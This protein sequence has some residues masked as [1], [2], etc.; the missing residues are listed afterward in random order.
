MKQQDIVPLGHGVPSEFPRLV[1]AD[2]VQRTDVVETIEATE[3]ERI[4]L[5]ERLDLVSVDRL[6]ATVRMKSA[7]GG[8]MVRVTGS[9]EASVVQSCVVSLEPV[10]EEVSDEFVALF[11]PE[12]L[13]PK[14][15]DEIYIDPTSEDDDF[16]EPIINGKI[17]IGELVIQQLS[18][19]L[20]PYPR[21]E[22]AEFAG[23]GDADDEEIMVEEVET[24]VRP[25]PFAALE[26]LKPK[27]KG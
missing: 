2:A 15:E 5:A 19:A 7:R 22:G 23:F 24:P 10:P 8:Q 3:Q 9:L 14:E 25:N 17:D 1:R 12:S 20:D 26:R 13:I 27:D 21:A 6:V 4:R 11:A 16:P 18:L